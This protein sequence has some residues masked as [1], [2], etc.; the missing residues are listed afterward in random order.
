V[1]AVVRAADDDGPPP[2]PGP[3]DGPVDDRPSETRENR[4][5]PLAQ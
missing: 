4:P 3:P 2:P 1:M 5:Q